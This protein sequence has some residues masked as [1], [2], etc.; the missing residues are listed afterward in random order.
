VSAEE[1]VAVEQ[2]VV[3]AAAIAF[4][5]APHVADEHFVLFVQHK[6]AVAPV[7]PYLEGSLKL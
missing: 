5:P 2:S 6:S 3:A 4:L 7:A 1:Q